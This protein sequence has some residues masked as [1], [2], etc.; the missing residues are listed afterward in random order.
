MQRETYFHFTKDAVFCTTLRRN[1]DLCMRLIEIILGIKVHD[2]EYIDSQ[3]TIDHDLD[4]K[5]I[6]LDVYVEDDA[7]TVYDLEMQTSVERELPKRSRYYQSMIDMGLIEKG[8]LYED[9]RKSYV[10]FICTDDPFNRGLSVYRFVKR[11]NEDSGLILGDETETVFLNAKGTKQ[12][13]D[14][15][16]ARFLD[17]LITHNPT[18][19]FTLRLEEQVRELNKDTEWRRNQMTV[20]MEMKVLERHAKAEGKAEGVAEG[21]RQ[22]VL[23]YARDGIITPEKAASDLGMSVEELKKLISET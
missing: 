12:G 18:S 10:A 4:S 8:S 16:L 7:H 5:G 21:M 19:D 20:G 14:E 9:L 6:R 2:I 1:K 15:E 13:I 23:N 3:K 17:Y 22:T 11:C